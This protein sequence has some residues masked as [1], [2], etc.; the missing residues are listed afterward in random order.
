MDVPYTFCTAVVDQIKLNEDAEMIL[1]V[2]YHLIQIDE[3]GYSFTL[4]MAYEALDAW[5]IRHKD[6]GKYTNAK[7]LESCAGLVFLDAKTQALRLRSPLLMQYLRLNV[8][9]DEYH[10][11]HI[12]V[13]MRYLSQ[14]IF[15]SGACKS[16]KDLKK[17]FQAHPYLWY[18][19]RNL[20]PSLAGNVNVPESFEADFLKLTAT[21]GLIESYLQAAEAWPYLDE[22]TYDECEESEERWRCFTRGYTS[23]HLAAHLGLRETTIQMLIDRGVD[24]EALT[25]NGQTALHM[26]AE[27]EDDPSTLR[28]LL[29]CGS[30]VAVVE[31]DSRTPLSHAIIY[32]NLTSV[33]LLLEHGADISAVDEEDLLE[34]L[35][36]KPEIAQFLVGL[37]VE[38]PEDNEE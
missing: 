37:G 29:Q 31:H 38:M 33:E 13:L 36:E 34:C 5:G 11:R 20:S 3:L 35:R 17:R 26:A 21:Q 28:C 18:A 1:C 9:G 24:V 19:A 4:P 22:E 10:T 6:G 12:A 14:D 23:L 16:S 27:I 30:D 15:S 2:L 32:G 7:I 25:E 8:F